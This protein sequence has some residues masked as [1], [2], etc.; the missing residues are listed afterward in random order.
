MNC[1][2]CRAEIKFI[3]LKSGKLI[4][5]NSV[6]KRIIKGEGNVRI[7]TE[8]GDIVSGRYDPEGDIVGYVSHFATCPNAS[9]HRRR[10]D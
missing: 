8:S 5:V 1:R 9:K 6:K 4:P 2:S 7:V 3:K 10:T